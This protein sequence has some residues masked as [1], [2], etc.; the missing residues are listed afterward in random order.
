MS[1]FSADDVAFLRRALELA[2]ENV[3]RGDGG[4]FGAVVVKDGRIIAEGWNRVIATCDP[5]AHAEV[6]AL[7]KA[8]AALSSFHL[9]G[10]TLYASSEPC[11]MCLAAAFWARVARI[12]HANP[13]LEAAKAGFADDAFYAELALPPEQ[14]QLPVEYLALPDANLPF[15][16]WHAKADKT[17]Y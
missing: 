12:V 14:R 5:T 6:E 13:R 16:L 11:P 17:L 15:A 2:R 8:G 9:A 4:P 7:R 1:S 10:T 3:A